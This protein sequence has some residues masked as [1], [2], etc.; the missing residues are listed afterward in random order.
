MECI[1]YDTQTCAMMRYAL[2]NLIEFI[3]D[4]E[5]WYELIA[6]YVISNTSK[7]KTKRNT[8]ILTFDVLKRACM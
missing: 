6:I 7:Q 4:G 2:L 3:Q 8:L 1:K 5:T